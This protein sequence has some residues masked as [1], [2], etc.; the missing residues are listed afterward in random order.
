MSVFISH[1]TALAYLRLARCEHRWLSRMSALRNPHL[2]F[3]STE[4]MDSLT[5]LLPD[6][7]FLH[8]TVSLPKYRRRKPGWRTSTHSG[9]LPSKSAIFVADDIIAASPELLF[10]QAHSFLSDIECIALG[11]ELC[12]SYARKG[13]DAFAY[14]LPPVTT[15]ARIQS[16]LNRCANTRHVKRAQRTIKFVLDGSASLREAQ[17]AMLVTL[18]CRLGGYGLPKP[19]LNYV[20]RAS[21]PA[22]NLSA[23]KCVDMAWPHSHVAVEYD[24]EEFHGAIDKISQDALRRTLLQTYG[25]EVVVV[26]NRQLKSPSECDK[27]A[28][29]LHRLLGKRQ[30]QSAI[31]FGDKNRCLRQTVL[32]LAF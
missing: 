32:A 1:E 8:V 3:P 20:V 15:A 7:A 26:T 28:R 29:A 4:Q 13:I 16:Y 21:A 9:A 24:S 27:I 11:F 18:P 17:L 6:Q 10:L 19:R 14:G 30:R 25:Y 22:S 31:G 2:V 5:R 12:G 23:S